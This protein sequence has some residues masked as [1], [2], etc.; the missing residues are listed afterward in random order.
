MGLAYKF[1]THKPRLTLV[2]P[3]FIEMIAGAL[4][5]GER[6]YS[7]PAWK[8]GLKFSRILD[9]AR[10][11]TAAIE[12]GEDIDP[13]SGYPHSAHVACCMMMYEYL[14][15]NWNGDEELDDRNF[16][17][18][19]DREDVPGVQDSEERQGLLPLAP[20]EEGLRVQEMQQRESVQDNSQAQGNGC[21]SSDS[22]GELSTRIIDWANR[23]FPG[24]TAETSLI[25]LT[26]EEI[27]E[28]LN[29]GLDDPLEFADVLILLI[30]VAY[31][32]GIDII[33][34]ANQ[35]MDINEQRH[36]TVDPNTGISHHIEGT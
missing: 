32:R 2:D 19:T 33:G 36:W 7:G 18:S 24:R 21:S 35:K 16:G 27:P 31:L 26:V 15:S 28:L 4:G 34:A 12:K 23:E 14:R 29:G 22:L 17:K 5:E 3:N 6:K 25:K 11:H 30:D 20:S 10:R 9:A 13:D 1:D 8:Q